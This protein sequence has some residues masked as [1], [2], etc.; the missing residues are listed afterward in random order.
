MKIGQQ[1]NKLTFKEYFFYIDNHKKYT[2]FNTLGLYR[3]IIES[4]KLTLT[5]KIEVREYAHKTFKKTFDFL[6]LK[7]PDT[8]FDIQTIGLTLTKADERQIWDD[9]IANQQKIL[10]DKRIKHRNFGIYSK[11]TCD[12]ETCRYH[13]VMI[14]QGS[15]IAERN[16]H[17][18]ADKNKYAGKDKSYRR[19]ADRKKEQQIIQTIILTE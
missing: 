19:K 9:I 12:Y 10:A 3:S 17:F 14:K 13:G 2:D 1:F 4:S 15:I 8:Y 7:D 18:N 6:Q 16:M 5:E 11:H